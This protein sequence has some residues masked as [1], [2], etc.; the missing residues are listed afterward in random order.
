MKERLAEHP[1]NSIVKKVGTTLVL[2]SIALVLGGCPS[3]GQDNS[4]NNPNMMNNPNYGP[5]MMP[6]TTMMTQQYGPGM[7]GNGSGMMGK[8]R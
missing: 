1:D 3:S 8:N 2:I 6:S 7:M 4:T 5:G